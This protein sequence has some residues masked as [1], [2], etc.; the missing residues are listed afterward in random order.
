[1]LRRRGERNRTESTINMLEQISTKDETAAHEECVHP[2]DVRVFTDDSGNLGVEIAGRGRWSK[3][4]VRQA[5][6]Y[7]EP[8]RFVS[9]LHEG[10]QIGMLRDPEALEADSREVLMAELARRYNVAEILRILDIGEAHNATTWRVETD[11][12]ARAFLVRDR[13]NFRRIKDGDLIIVDVD[14][15][16]FR[17]A[18]TRQLEPE[19]KRLL[20]TYG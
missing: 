14:G 3:V 15:N 4:A 20:D 18:R 10:E 2:G 5:F 19:S 17:L 13:H 8:G 11:R 1:M 12:G 16:R 9:F 6:P 7:S